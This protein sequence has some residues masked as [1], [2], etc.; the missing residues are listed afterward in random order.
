VEPEARRRFWDL[1]H[2][3]AAQ[4]VTILVTT[5]YMD[6]AEYCNRIALINAGRLVA[7]GS[8]SELRQRN[9]GGAL[10]ELEC[11]PLGGALIVLQQAAEVREVAIFGDK[12]HV[13]MRDAA[14]IG[15]LK[16]FLEQHG[17]EVGQSRAISPSLEDVFVQLVLRPDAK[18]RR[19]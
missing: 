6:E 17:I 1:I 10:I 19:E 18:E 8:P 9:L 12:L 7:I 16:P 4:S 15:Q 13:L 14:S 11:T 2:S 3:L 5:H